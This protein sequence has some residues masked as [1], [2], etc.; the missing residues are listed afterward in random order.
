MSEES[1]PARQSVHDHIAAVKSGAVKG[2]SL[3]P[4]I[5]Q[6][7]VEYLTSEG[8]GT[9]ELSKLLGM[10]DRTIRRDLTAIRD[11]NAL[12]ADPELADRLAGEFVSE[13]RR[14][15]QRIRRTTGDK[16][17]PHAARIDGERAICEIYDKLIGRLQSLGYA[18]SATHHVRA[19]LTHHLG[20]T[21]EYAEIRQE[22]DRV[23]ALPGGDSADLHELRLLAD[24]AESNEEKS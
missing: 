1:A 9:A 23:A 14:S 13:A 17:A 12:H 8:L 22:I 5:R 10:T 4:E 21:P 16:D 3:H 24:E 20:S 11:R 15:M 7:I 19:D 6:D 2:S 18:P